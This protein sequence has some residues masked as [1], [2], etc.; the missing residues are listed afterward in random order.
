MKFTILGSSMAFLVQCHEGFATEIEL[1]TIADDRAYV[2]ETHLDTEHR[3]IWYRSTFILYVLAGKVHAFIGPLPMCIK[4][5]Q[6]L[7]D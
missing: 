6:L 1:P 2:P 3:K 4:K 5:P 7:Q